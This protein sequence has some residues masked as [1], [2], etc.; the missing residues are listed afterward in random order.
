MGS[1]YERKGSPYW[2][3]DYVDTEGVRQRVSTGT[4]DKKKAEDFLKIREGKVAEGVHVSPRIDRVT[5]NEVR[6]N[7]LSHYETSGDWKDMEE[8]RRRIAHL[9]KFFGRDRVVSIATPR[10]R[11]YVE[12]RLNEKVPP[13]R[14]TDKAKIESRVVAPAT[15]NR[16]LAL[17]RRMLRLG[18]DD[19]LI[20][21]L[22]KIKMLR[23]A[24]ARAGFVD[25]EKYRSLMNALKRRADLQCVVA[26]GYAFG[27]RIKSEVLTLERRQVDLEV[28]TLRLDAGSTKN[29]EGRVVYLTPEIKTMLAAQLERVDELQKKLGRI[30]PF[31]FPYLRR[32]RAGTRI[33]EFRKAWRSACRR[34]GVPG[35]LLHDLRRSAV[36]NMERHG[37]PRSHAMKITGHKT[38]SIYRRYAIVSDA[39]LREASRRIAAPTAQEAGRKAGT[40]QST[41]QSALRSKMVPA[42]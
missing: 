20:A 37:V 26:I 36:R 5:Y 35:L 22:P 3:A 17:L 21:R 39:D 33:V 9:T 14:E 4:G 25:D 6:D 38:E 13:A 32:R 24:P 18:A 41:S 2:W 7:L 23:E 16:E 8:A 1:L 10:V 29:K 42:K 40:S 12:K 31:V 30:I 27:W 34:A 28:G 19:G 15:V 11:A